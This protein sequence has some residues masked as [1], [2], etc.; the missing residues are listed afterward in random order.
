MCSTRMGLA[1]LDSI[2]NGGD[3]GNILNSWGNCTLSSGT[4][5]TQNGSIRPII[6]LAKN[7]NLIYDDSTSGYIIK[8]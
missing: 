8:Q 7:I 2:Q 1:K 3:V 5:W 4:K 6:C